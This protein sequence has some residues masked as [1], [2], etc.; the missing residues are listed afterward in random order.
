M[1]GYDFRLSLINYDFNF[2]G[3]I[4]RAIESNSAKSI[5][6]IINT[7]FEHSNSPLYN[8]LFN[9]EMHH[10]FNSDLI[11]IPMFFSRQE[12]TGSRFG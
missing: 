12:A 8:N 6:A 11:S 1:A 3:T 5:K 7:I 2:Q 10:I 4:L 9:L